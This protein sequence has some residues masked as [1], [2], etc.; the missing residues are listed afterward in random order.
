MKGVYQWNHD[1]ERIARRIVHPQ[2]VVLVIG[3]TDTG[4][5][6]FCRFLVEQGVSQGLRVGLVDADVGQSQIGPPSTIGLKIL[7]Q[8]PDW[9]EIE[10]DNLYFVG[11]ISPEGHLLRCITGVR[12]MVDAA[13]SAGANYVV[14]DTTGYVKG[15][16]A[17][18]LK[19]HKIEIIKPRHLVCI[20]HSD[21]LD[22]IAAGF[23]ASRSMKIYRLPPHQRATSKTS[24]FRRQ[25]RE[26]RVNRYFS[27][28][29]SAVIPFDQFRGQ[30]T[31]FFA[32]RRANRKEL[33]I[34]SG[35][36]NN[37]VI[38]GEWGHRSITLVSQNVLSDHA[39]T[40]IKSR[41]SLTNLVART[42]EYFERRFVGLV[43][44]NGKLVSVGIIQAA[45]F[46]ANH[47]R[48]RCRLGTSEHTKIVQFGRYKHECV[49]GGKESTASAVD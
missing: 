6:T 35:L 22:A 12:L 15:V 3:S 14:I 25:Y 13:L 27:E 48:V 29:A 37:Q 7:S 44:A 2:A 8:I 16:G 20:Q 26:S 24:K 45:D 46:D 38:Y 19:Q 36:A 33:E 5:T 23:D 21:E 32:G 41:L 17:I 11:W 9:N 34:L 30:G 43:D 28:T 4:K 31:P 10:A 39:R 47:L 42:P 49:N 18:K 1:W 40:R